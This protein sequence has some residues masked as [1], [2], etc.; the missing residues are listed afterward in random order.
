V[1]THTTKTYTDMLQTINDKNIPFQVVHRGDKINFA[2]NIDVTVLNPGKTYLTSDPINQNSVVLRVVDGKVS[3]LF[4]GDAG[5]QAEED[6]MQDGMNVQADILKVGHHGSR[7]ASGQAF[8]DAVKPE[9]SIVSV[10]AGNKYGL[11]DEDA[12]ARIQAVS[13]LYRTD[14]DGSV[15]VTTDGSTYTV[16]T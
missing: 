13:K 4:T 1:K 8:I 14:S 12:L 15:V 9:V 11:P 10:G 6:L 5:I 7:T 16:T 2:P 3:F